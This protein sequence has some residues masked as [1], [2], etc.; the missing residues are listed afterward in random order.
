MNNFRTRMMGL[1]DNGDSTAS[2]TNSSGAAVGRRNTCNS[3][4]TESYALASPPLLGTVSTKRAWAVV[5]RKLRGLH[6]LPMIIYVRENPELVTQAMDKLYG[7]LVST[8]GVDAKDIKVSD[9]P[10]AFD[11]PSAVRKMSKDRH[12][13][14]V[15]GLLTKDKLWFDAEQISKVRNYL[16]TWSQENAIPLIDG[17]LIDDDPLSL[18]N[19]ICLPEWN[20]R[21]SEDIGFVHFPANIANFA[22]DDAEVI[23]PIRESEPGDADESR[24]SSVSLTANL[25]SMPAVVD[26]TA[27]KDYMFG[28]YLAHR[29]IEMFY[30]E[31]RGW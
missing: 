21:A 2:N 4:A 19:R 20:I 25:S 12:I 24:S 16:L 29:A 10:T 6:P 17:I 22:D 15:V 1:N 31:H 14:I 23:S 5:P 30:F 9:V 3:T 7:T 27:N 26:A 13:I 11:L 18:R 28:H 8:Y